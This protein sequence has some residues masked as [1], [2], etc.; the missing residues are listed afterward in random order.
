VPGTAPE[1]TFIVTSSTRAPGYARQGQ[2]TESDEIEWV[3]QAVVDGD[4]GRAWN[5]AAERA[6]GNLLIFLPPDA[7][8][9]PEF[10]AAHLAVHRLHSR[11]LALGLLGGEPEAG[12]ARPAEFCD[13]SFSIRRAVLRAAGG[14]IRGLGWGV[15]TEL[16]FRLARQGVYLVR[17][18]GAVGTR[19][20]QGG[21]KALA[22]ERAAAGRGSVAL[23]QRVPALLPELELGAFG[24]ASH[25]ALLLRRSLLALGA[26]LWPLAMVSISRR[27][28]ERGRSWK[29]FLRSY[30][31]WRGVWQSVTDRDMRARL[32][33][34]PIMLMYHAIGDRAERAGR[35]I[36]PLQRFTRQLAWL[37]SAKYRVVS[38]EEILEHRRT[39]R[40]PPPRAVV[41]TFDDG[42]QD[43][44]RLA[45][46]LLRRRGLR[47]A[48]F[49][50]SRR[51][52]ETNTWDSSGELAGRPLMS[53][54]EVR[55]LAESGMEIGAHTRR[56]VV[57]PDL[58][59]EE[60]R[61]EIMGSRTDLEERLG[62]L[63]RAFA[64][65]YGRLDDATV[66]AAEQAGFECACSTR[67]GSN[68]PGVR[69]HRLRRVEVRGTD[70][71]IQFAIAVWRRSR[72]TGK[73]TRS[74][75]PNASCH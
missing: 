6:R 37:R 31:Y 71:L 38:I 30:L 50:V 32:A 12:A 35:Y 56:H 55:Q 10:V 4:V 29:R 46:P 26:P 28:G 74:P 43:N 69:S 22:A 58:P 72:P 41:L 63:V 57:L 42:Y 68:D 24:E 65:P 70:T 5:E 52:G 49:L 1:C 20:A 60:R 39:Y 14:F 23:Y 2:A 61:A 18:A 17:I 13:Q 54:A 27:H 34:P 36:T 7:Q 47:A 15:E 21:L 9:A 3:E 19:T 66:E 11:A 75:D 67:S 16:A 33:Q 62:T 59:P 25:R 73:R 44:Y 48:F 51:I 64:Y 40:L 45:W 53:W 8:P